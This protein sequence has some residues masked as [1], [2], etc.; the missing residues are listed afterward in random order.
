MSIEFKIT[1]V[2]KDDSTA[3][4]AVG[5]RIGASSAKKFRYHCQALLNAG[6][7]NLII[8]MRAVDFIASSGAGTLVVLSEAFHTKGGT[9]QIINASEPVKRVIGLLNIGRFVTL[10]EDEEKAMVNIPAH[11]A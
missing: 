1:D 7:V 11:D 3:V 9:V 4:V 10:V 5:G 2:R 6:H 8:D